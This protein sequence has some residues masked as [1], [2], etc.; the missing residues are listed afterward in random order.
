VSA[1]RRKDSQR[2]D[3]TGPLSSGRID[4]DYVEPTQRFS[5]RSKHAQQ[6]KI[7]RT[8]EL[9]TADTVVAADLAGLPVGE[10]V[11]V[12]S[13]FVDVEHEGRVHRCVK[14]KTL[15]KLR[16]TQIVVGD[17]V[18]FRVTADQPDAVIEQV[19]DR[20]TVLTRADSFNSN[21]QH[22]IVAN[23]EQMLIVASL[24]SPRVKWGLVD[25]MIVAAQGGGL[26]PIVCLNKI[27]AA[28]RGGER[29]EALEILGYYRSM[30]VEALATSVP[31]G[32][33]IEVLTQ[34]LRGRTTVLAGHSG[35]GKSSLIRAVQSDLDIRIGDVSSVNEKGRHTTTS[36]RIYR[37]KMG[38]V[39]IDTPGVKTFGLWGVSRE[40]VGD[41]FPD[42]GAGTAPEWRVQSME[43]IVESLGE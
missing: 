31:E 8:A 18:R 11:Q 28:Q 37:L 15:Q 9:R 22:P 14:R 26:R 42:V 41:F 32:I 34:V 13:V 40:N 2:R 5:R 27:D 19:L 12:H 29:D 25:R 7:E 3:R 43:R 16:S 17:R 38:G 6:N 4:E 10:V 20:K 30:K 33:D 1:Q 24:R 35:V 23:A 39:V 21:V 36:A